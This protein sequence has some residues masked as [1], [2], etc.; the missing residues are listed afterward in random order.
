MRGGPS[1]TSKRDMLSLISITTMLLAVVTKM[2]MKINQVTLYN[3]M[4][5]TP[6]TRSKRRKT[7]SSSTMIT[8]VKILP[9]TQL[10]LTEIMTRK[11]QMKIGINNWAITSSSSQRNNKIIKQLRLR[12]LTKTTITMITKTRWLCN[13]IRAADFAVIPQQRTFQT[14]R[15]MGLILRNQRTTTISSEICSHLIN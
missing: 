14:S 1:G 2:T 15:Q 12:Y 6:R 3:S 4:R 13:R 8:R 10:D 9:V 11:F 5:A 7:R